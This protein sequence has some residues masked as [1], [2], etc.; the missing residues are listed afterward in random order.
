MDVLSFRFLYN[1]FHI[2]LERALTF[3]YLCLFKLYP[4]HL[5]ATFSINNSIVFINSLCANLF[6]N[7]FL[8]FPI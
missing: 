4:K 8:A 6:G 2:S 3:L 7:Y 1:L 5:V